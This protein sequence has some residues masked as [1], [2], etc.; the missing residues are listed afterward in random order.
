MIGSKLGPYE[1]TEQIGRGGMATVYRAY[2]P[3][4]D[5][6]VA[7]KVISASM[8]E[9]T[10]GRDRF[11]REAK[12]VAKLEHPHLL[13]VYDFDGA[14]DPPYIVMRFLEGGTLKQVMDADPLPA[15]EMLFM[16]RQVAT[17]LDYAH[18]QGIVHRDLKPSNIMIDKE[19]N[20]FIADFGIARVSNAA[21]D[22]TGTGNVIGTPGYMAPE[23]ARAKVEL[24]GRA[25]IYSLGVIIYELLAGQGPYEREN[26]L[27]ELMAHMNDPVPDIREA[28]PELP[29]E[30]SPVVQ[31][32]MAK[33]RDERYS[34]S[35]ELVDELG[36][37]LKKQ[38]SNAPSQLRSLTQ[39]FAAEQLAA[40]DVGAADAKTPSD[41][42]RQMTVLYM[43]MTDFADLLYESEE[44]D[45]VQRRT[46]RLWHAFEGIAS[47]HGGELE[48]RTGEVGLMLWGLEE[49]HESDPD[50]AIHA[51]L[52][53]KQQI[54][55]LAI[56]QWGD[57][58]DPLPF[59]AG[60]TT[61]PVLLTRDATGG[62]TA[63]GTTITLAGR[64][65]ESA[66]P[67]DILISHD[68]FTHVRGI[69]DMRQLPPVRMRGRKDPLDVYVAVRAR[70][71]AF[72]LQPRG[73]E[74]VET[75]MVGREPEF[76]ILQDALTLTIEDRE[77]QVV[78]V[79]G[80][81]G[82]GKS[83]LLYEFSNWVDV[84]DQTVWFFEARATQPSMLQPYSLTR[85]LFSFRFQIS[86]NDPLPVV[87]Q[88]FEEGVAGFMNGASEEVAPL[89]G[90]LVGFDFSENPAVKPLL[91]DPE[92][93]HRKAL[94]HLGEFFLTASKTNPVF[95]QVEDIHWADDRSL[96]LLNSL[97]RENVDL[98]LFIIYMARP[99]LFDRRSSW[100]EGQEYHA[101]I[102]L[103]PLSRLDS[104]RLVRELLKKVDKVPGELRD[105]IID[106]AEGN[107]F[108]MEELIKSLIDDGVILKG[109]D[110]WS[111]EMDRL[112]QARVPTTLVG[113]LQSR[114]DTFPPGQRGLLQRASVIGRIFWESAAV[115][116]SATEDVTEGAVASM[117]KDLR[118]RE[119]VFQREASAFEGT[120]EYGFR[121][122]ILRDVVYETIVPRQRRAYHKLVAEWLIQASAE[123]LDEYS[124]LIAEHFERADEPSKAA[125]YLQRA[126]SNGSV[127]G[128]IDEALSVSH[129]AL[130]LLAGEEHT[131]QRLPLQILMGAWYGFKGAYPEAIA[132][133]EPALAS[134]RELG[135]RSTEAKALAELGRI[136]GVWQND[137]EA[138]RSYFDQALEIA[139]ELNDKP[140]LIFIGRQ[141][142]N[143][144]NMTGDF[145]MARVK[146]QESRELARE[147]QDG[148]SEANALNS[149]GLTATAEGEFEQALV[150]YSEGL[151]LAES[152]GDRGIAGMIILNTA[153]VYLL[154]DHVEEG[155]RAAQKA[156]DM[157]QEIGS[158]Y[159]AAGAYRSLGDGLIS[160]GDYEAARENLHESLR[161]TKA[162]GSTIFFMSH[163]V[164]QYG[165]LRARSGDQQGGLELL[166]LAREQRYL[167]LSGRIYFD[168][169]L[170]D[171]RGELSDKEV[172]AA[173]KRGAKLDLDRVVEEL[174]EQG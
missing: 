77:T 25:D 12:L 21:R 134:A 4:M 157:V 137:H 70:P 26:A 130:G 103:N 82:V 53:M 94:G 87:H 147:Q 139:R 62:T 118:R 29:S 127:V 113:V 148:E 149:L 83:R 35:G 89:I 17:A 79:V 27:E 153:D 85:D 40:L 47:Q 63:S 66:P 104:R 117:L 163:I 22:L 76:K 165:R 156:L 20:A 161:L 133:F 15:E 150:F 107:P 92:A 100:G 32:A 141:L 50:Q 132:Q 101:R 164:L 143:L 78:T 6:H 90:Q 170:E 43:D 97:A 120:T 86:D 42:Q 37:A 128:T 154:D 122:A 57:S 33:D 144:G 67:G 167:L 102:T 116:L 39:T 126:A 159:L 169:A 125:E 124:L 108:Y 10:V 84:L 55:K 48:S 45:E 158:D 11:Q 56:A 152:M 95:V 7:L 146:L 16:L 145:E 58:E 91:E 112:A 138:G 114:L 174:L 171:V 13:P 96:D 105:L 14:H 172:E 46:D 60:I 136:V 5:R 18:R 168:K 2:Q 151:A 9:D 8:L 44:A 19:G 3:S 65:K 30:L 31:K 121:H 131:A 162:M 49:I 99:E 140:A 61:G 81:A 160:K 28:N 80:E 115:H 73:I 54:E 72:K 34:T 135:D 88:K 129:K 68:T 123:R 75:K 98:P 142:G 111:V 38:A 24:D 52:T 109:E 71:R 166:G 64:L 69:F 93:F 36:K 23:Q 59:K 110:E 119:M 74:G 173:L 41:V 1:I 155:L 51:A 106:R